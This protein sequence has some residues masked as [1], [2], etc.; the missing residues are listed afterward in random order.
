MVRDPPGAAQELIVFED[1][2]HRSPFQEPE[3]FFEVMT[4]TVLTQA[5]RD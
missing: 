3:R 4:E 2:G 1:S 5:T